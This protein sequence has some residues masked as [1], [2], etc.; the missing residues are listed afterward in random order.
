[1]S[2]SQSTAAAPS[3]AYQNNPTRADATNPENYNPEMASGRVV[4][5]NNP[6]VTRLALAGTSIALSSIVPLIVLVTA[7][8]KP[9]QESAP[10]LAYADGEYYDPNVLYKDDI[11]IPACIISCAALLVSGVSLC[12][13][14]G[15]V[16]VQ[17]RHKAIAQLNSGQEMV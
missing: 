3:G 8:D 7:Q 12:A 16:F 5:Q 6:M 17:A 1:M 9:V 14:S 2:V 11:S 10:N 13:L 15:Y 4:A